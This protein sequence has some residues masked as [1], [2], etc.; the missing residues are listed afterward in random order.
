M[1]IVLLFMYLTMLVGSF[2]FPQSKK[3]AVL[4]F[5]LFCFIFAFGRF[6]GDYLTYQWIYSEFNTGLYNREFEPLFSLTFWVATKIGLPFAIYRLFVGFFICT[7]MFKLIE[8]HTSCVA[9]SAALYGCFPFF[10]YTAVIR[11]GVASVFVLIAIEQ[12]MRP[13][14]D[15]RRFVLYIIIATLFHY[16][17]FFFIFLLLFDGRIK[18]STVLII[19]FIS[20]ALAIVL[21]YTPIPYKIVSLLTSR[22]K[23]LQWFMKSDDATANI[24]GIIG[25]LFLIVSMYSMTRYNL[26]ISTI[27]SAEFDSDNYSC[28]QISSEL[29]YYGV[30][31][32]AEANESSFVSE[33]YEASVSH[34]LS[35]MMI[36]FAPL[37]ILA[38]PFTRLP[39]M[40]FI[41]VIITTINTGMKAQ[42]LYSED[43]FRP[44]R[45][46]LSWVLLL[47]VS[48]LWKVYFDLPYLKEGSRFFWEYLDV[49]FL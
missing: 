14:P 37:M 43:G 49:R 3:L 38:S 2:F 5:S 46:S 32:E 28:C 25:I 44:G 17:S 19:L 1:N 48:L 27:T 21:N 29:H 24:N 18:Q 4:L 34:R 7:Q 35:I 33:Y 13:N 10:M 22:Q 41:F 30:L 40:V 45:V 11:S 6:Q 36:L 39:F 15:R 16:S 31:E 9:L 42:M 8:R 12:L 26:S 47:F 20:M 23:T